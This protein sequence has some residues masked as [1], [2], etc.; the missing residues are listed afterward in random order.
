MGGMDEHWKLDPKPFQPV[1]NENL[2]CNTC[3]FKTRQTANCEKYEVKPVSVLKGGACYAY[4]K[5]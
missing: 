3:K 2:T 1:K 4:K 5:K